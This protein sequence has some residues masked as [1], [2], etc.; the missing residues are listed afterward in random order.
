[1]LAWS[2][3]LTFGLLASASGSPVEVLPQPPTQT[4]PQDVDE[5]PGQPQVPAGA[6]SR[7]FRFLRDPGGSCL[8]SFSPD[9]LFLASTNRCQQVSILNLGTGRPVWLWSYPELLDTSIGQLVWP[10]CQGAQPAWRGG[11]WRLI[12]TPPAPGWPGGHGA[13]F[14]PDGLTFAIVHNPSL[15]HT[16]ALVND[17]DGLRLSTGIWLTGGYVHILARPEL[18][19]ERSIETEAP[20]HLPLRGAVFGGLPRVTAF[21]YSPRGDLIATGSSDGMLTLWMTSSGNPVA[22]ERVEFGPADRRMVCSLDFSPSGHRIATIGDDGVVRLWSV[23][24]LELDAELAGHSMRGYW[25]EFSPDEQ[26]GASA[27]R[28]GLLHIW[29]LPGQRA[30]RTVDWRTEVGEDPLFTYAADGQS[31]LFGATRERGVVG[32]VGAGP[33]QTLWSESVALRNVTAFATS[34]LGDLL[35]AGDE[36]G[37][38]LVWL[39][40]PTAIP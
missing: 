37:K 35:A 11:Q 5:G 10:F 39:M 8:L 31:I 30:L 6:L 3:L 28:D 24:A 17:S 15:S 34:P 20:R 33:R 29:D 13:F 21:G 36:T 26:R 9:G 23:P 14:A 25:V 40:A 18:L 32:V 1:M 22:R 27:G 38:I 2:G 12:A 4:P 16:H 19:L 7:P